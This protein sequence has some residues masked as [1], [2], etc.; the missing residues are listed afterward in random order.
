[1][2]RVRHLLESA[3]G[4]RRSI[5]QSLAAI[6]LAV[7]LAQ[8][9][10]GPGSASATPAAAP[11]VAQ[12]AAPKAASC[13]AGFSGSPE[14]GCADVNECAIAN[15]GCNLL[16]T[17]MNTPGSR[18]CGSCPLDF[19]GDGYVGCFDVNECPN[20]DCSGRLP[21]NTEQAP[22]PVVSTGGDVTAVASSE[23][24]AAATFTAKATDTIDGARPAHCS[25]ASGSVFPIGKTTV[26]CWA[27]NSRGK[28]AHASLVVTVS[29][30]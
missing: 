9:F 10:D 22:P 19:A 20:G 25:P 27:T 12:A 21:L 2:S 15:G 5:A 26:S 17:C 1:M 3:L 29:P 23:K 14:K 7:L 11:P 30:K 4:S 28:L 8:L 13:Q 16:A 6:V 24:G 18:T